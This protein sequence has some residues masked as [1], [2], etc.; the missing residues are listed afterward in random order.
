MPQLY[1]WKIPV[2]RPRA[3]NEVSC[4]FPLHQGPE[5]PEALMPLADCQTISHAH[6]LTL[7]KD[8]LC[9]IDLEVPMFHLG[10]VFATRHFLIGKIHKTSKCSESD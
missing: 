8:T 7:Y 5:Y 1:V 4:V 3:K 6:Q 2:D 10:S 9:R